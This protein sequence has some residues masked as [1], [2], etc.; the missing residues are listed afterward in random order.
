MNSPNRRSTDKW[1]GKIK[2]IGIVFSI[3]IVIIGFMLFLGG[4][5][6]EITENTAFRKKTQPLITEIMTRMGG[7][8]KTFERSFD[9]MDKKLNRLLEK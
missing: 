2:T 9:N 8:E 4:K 1:N 5:K 7:L 6:L 3:T